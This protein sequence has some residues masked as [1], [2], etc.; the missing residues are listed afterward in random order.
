MG[1][2]SELTGGPVQAL[3]SSGSSEETVDVRYLASCIHGRG[4]AQAHTYVHAPHTLLP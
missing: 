2:F 3:V 4:R 1:G